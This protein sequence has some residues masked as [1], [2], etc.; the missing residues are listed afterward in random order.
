MKKAVGGKRKAAA[1]VKESSESPLP[2]RYCHWLMKSEPESRFENG[3]DVKV[4]RQRRHHHNQHSVGLSVGCTSLMPL[5][6]S[7]VWDRGSEGFASSDQLLGRR[8]QLSGMAAPQ[9]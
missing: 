3:V 9:N 6:H 5:V 7:A 2:P 4:N 1:S 8:T